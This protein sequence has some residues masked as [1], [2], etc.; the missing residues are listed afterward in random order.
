MSG[1]LVILSLQFMFFP[2]T[3]TTKLFYGLACYLFIENGLILRPREA[4][5]H[6]TCRK[7]DL[8][9]I[10]VA[11]GRWQAA[12]DKLCTLAELGPIDRAWT[13]S[14]AEVRFPNVTFEPVELQVGLG[15]KRFFQ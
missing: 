13:A 5:H 11:Q 7:G 12:D 3:D 2:S 9:D 1:F 4:L 10:S 8:T 15:P 6:S 14:S